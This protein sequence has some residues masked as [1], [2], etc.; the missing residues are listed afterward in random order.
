[1]AT[2]LN[3]NAGVYRVEDVN[4]VMVDVLPEASVESFSDL[5]GCGFT[6][7][8]GVVFAPIGDKIVA[9]VSVT[10]LASGNG[11]FVVPVESPAKGMYIQKVITDPAADGDAP[12]EYTIPVV[13]TDGATVF[14]VPARSTSAIERY[15]IPSALTKNEILDSDWTFT[16]T[17][18]GEGNIVAVR[19]IFS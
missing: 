13:D 18:I 4:G 17:G 19:V 11:A 16:L 9:S 5:S 10:G 1:M 14:T 8:G 15:D 7:Q 2:W 6:N 3:G 12:A